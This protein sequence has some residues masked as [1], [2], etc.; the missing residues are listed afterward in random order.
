M[1]TFSG[2]EQFRDLEHRSQA[3]NYIMPGE[4]STAM[5]LAL[6]NKFLKYIFTPL[7]LQPDTVIHV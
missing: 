2:R 6:Q 7:V 4:E 3:H 1:E 5:V